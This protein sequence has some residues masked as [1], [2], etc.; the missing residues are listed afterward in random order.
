MLYWFFIAL[1]F[2]DWFQSENEAVASAPVENEEARVR[3]DICDE[4]S[5]TAPL[6]L[7]D[8]PELPSLN[9]LSE[10]GPDSLDEIMGLQ[11]D[12]EVY[13]CNYAIF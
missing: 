8:E 5:A 1:V 12:K 4:M 11:Q 10:L 9:S 2:I 13:I 6:I 7:F 3:E